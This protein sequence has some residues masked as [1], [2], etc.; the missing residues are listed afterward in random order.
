MRSHKTLLKFQRYPQLYL[1]TG[2]Q[3]DCEYLYVTNQVNGHRFIL[4]RFKSLLS[5][6]YITKIHRAE[7]HINEHVKNTND[8][9]LKLWHDRL[10]HPGSV[11]MYRIISQSHGH[12]L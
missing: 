5:G 6:L 11:M 9:E 2:Y 10:G 8:V 1:E 4:E 3:S 7:S 12:N